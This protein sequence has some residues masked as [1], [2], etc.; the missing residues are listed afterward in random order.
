MEYCQVVLAGLQM[1]SVFRS[2]RTVND[3]NISVGPDCILV[4]YLY[5]GLAGHTM[6]YCQVVQ[7]GLQMI[8][9]FW[10]AHGWRYGI[11][12]SGAGQTIYQIL[13]L[14]A[15]PECQPDCSG[16][17]T[18][19]WWSVSYIIIYYNLV[20]FALTYALDSS[21]SGPRPGCIIFHIS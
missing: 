17:P 9:I 7:A 15:K 18:F 16:Q 8:S 21:P 14:P 1:I 11:F 5:F 4:Q 2:G 12:P 10:S 13:V 19:T 6:E 20:E 3:I